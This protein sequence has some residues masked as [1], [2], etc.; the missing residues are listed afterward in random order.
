MGQAPFNDR[1]DAVRREI[2]SARKDLR[3]GGWARL[4]SALMKLHKLGDEE[5]ALRHWDSVC[6]A[7]LGKSSREVFE[8]LG[9]HQTSE[10]L[11]EVGFDE[12]FLRGDEAT[13]DRKLAIANP[14]DFNHWAV[15][16]AVVKYRHFKM[17]RRPA[18]I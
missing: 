6:R 16:K 10:Q 17:W 11:A 3:H 18:S 1:Y 7:I 13:I 2:E 4:Y 8:L 14:T 9:F 5:P 15:K 12:Q